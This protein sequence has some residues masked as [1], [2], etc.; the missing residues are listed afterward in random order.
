MTDYDNFTDQDTAGTCY[1]I[2]DFSIYD[3]TAYPARAK[4]KFADEYGVDYNNC[5][6][7]LVGEYVIVAEVPSNG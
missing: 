4:S 6:A 3:T 1:E 5:Y 2:D 7:K